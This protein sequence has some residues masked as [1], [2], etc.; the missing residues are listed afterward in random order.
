MGEMKKP[1]FVGLVITVIVIAV[2]IVLI[3]SSYADLHYYEV[4]A[5]TNIV[6]R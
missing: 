2:I 3:T 1:V 6:T 5:V 4:C